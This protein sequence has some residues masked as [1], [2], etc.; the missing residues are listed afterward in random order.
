ML[1]A[2]LF[3]F[4]SGF[5]ACTEE[6][7][8]LCIPLACTLGI[9]RGAGGAHFSSDLGSGWG[10]TGSESRGDHRV[11]LEMRM[12]VDKEFVMAREPQ[13]GAPPV[14]VAEWNTCTTLSVCPGLASALKP[15]Q[16][17]TG[18]T[19]TS[20]VP[21]LLTSQACPVSEEMFPRPSAS[22]PA[23]HLLHTGVRLSVTPPCHGP[24]SPCSQPNLGKCWHCPALA[25]TPCKSARLP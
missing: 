5:K 21:L 10:S 16:T 14:S 12:C 4:L 9:T 23:L 1:F 15:A 25:V 3:A 6:L 24:V 20:R 13:P 17:S 2:L 8:D 22:C 11:P 7:T 19:G 18:A